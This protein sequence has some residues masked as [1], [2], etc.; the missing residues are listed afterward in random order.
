MNLLT[1][2]VLIHQYDFDISFYI[3]LPSTYLPL[4]SPTSNQRTNQPLS[5]RR[6]KIKQRPI[7]RSLGHLLL[8]M[9]IFTSFEAPKLPGKPKESWWVGDVVRK[10]GNHTLVSGTLSHHTLLVSVKPTI[11]PSVPLV[12]HMVVKTLQH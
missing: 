6:L 1:T 10:H 7:V 9:A 4:P 11:H 8:K 12:R 2:F 3:P 5:P